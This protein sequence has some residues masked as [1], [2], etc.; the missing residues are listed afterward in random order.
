M[1]AY[2]HIFTQ[3]RQDRRVATQ[4]STHLCNDAMRLDQLA[5]IRLATLHREA[6]CIRANTQ[7]PHNV[8]M[9]LQNK[10]NKS[11]HRAKDEVSVHTLS[12]L[13]NVTHDDAVLL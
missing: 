5:Q 11:I 8:G 6:H 9:S 12:T 2:T 10:A 3:Y 4:T 13:H 7:D 1:H